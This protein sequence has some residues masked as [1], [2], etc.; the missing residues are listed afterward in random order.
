[1]NVCERRG[2][3]IEA[4]GSRR[5]SYLRPLYGVAVA[6]GAMMGAAHGEPNVAAA[7]RGP[8]MLSALP[9]VGPT[10]TIIDSELR[11]FTAVNA[12][13]CA[14]L[15]HRAAALIGSHRGSLRN[16]SNVPGSRSPVPERCRASERSASTR[17]R[18]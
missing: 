11:A 16:L 10:E 6:L 5:H 4:G 17:F 12:L 13:A 15:S 2:E 14:L 9:R 18:S 3:R 8:A 7:S 1:M